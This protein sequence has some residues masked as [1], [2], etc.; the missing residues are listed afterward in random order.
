MP[1]PLS[2]LTVRPGFWSRD[3][4]F[5]RLFALF[6]LLFALCAVL[7]PE[8]F[9]RW[10][11]FQSMAKQFPEFGLMAIGVALAMLTGGIDLSIVN[12]ANLSAVA[13]AKIMVTGAPRGT[14]V[15][16]TIRVIIT[17]IA[18]ALALGALCGIVNGLLI[19]KIGIPAILA[20]LGSGQLFMGLAI[21]ITNGRPVSGLP[22]LYS[23]YGNRN[24]GGSIPMVL[25]VFAACALVIGLILAKTRFGA[26]LYMLGSN[27]K[28]AAFTG[29]K[30]ARLIILTY[31]MSGILGAVAGLIM[32]A[33]SNSAKAD[34]GISYTMQSILV[35]VLGGISPNGGKGNVIGVVMAVLIL[36]LLSSALN[37]FENISNFY[38][39]ILW[40]VVMIGV[41]IT[42]YYINAREV[43]KQ[44]QASK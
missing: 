27:A 37:M 30:N 44:Q 38:R 14:P 20:T 11:N 26:K 6:I 22:M 40:G 10:S 41:L 36:Q 12:I 1:E 31:M 7:K 25:V 16:Q 3:K 32:M 19:S 42:N 43:R 33:R 2:P 13:A 15:D 35:A 4:N 17:A 9:L 18:V 29:L 23:R 39:D 28:A 34:Y 8:L 24:L 21:V 5:T